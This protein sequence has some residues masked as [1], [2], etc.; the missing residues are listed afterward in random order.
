MTGT[1]LPICSCPNPH[2][3]Y[4]TT[5]LLLPPF[6][7]PVPYYPSA[8]API[9]MTGTILP[10]CSCPRSHDRYYTTHLLLPHS[11]D[12]YY[13]AHMFL[14]QS[15]DRY[16]S[17]HLLLPPFTRPVLYYPSA[18]APIHTTGTI[19]P[20]CSCPHSHELYYPSAPA[21]I[22]TTGTIQ[23]ICS[24]PHSHDRYYTTHLLL[25]PFT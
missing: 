3:R 11:H 9:H 5:H 10:I 1:I 17:A 18:P 23:P 8:P 19:L 13:T 6:T 7:R 22:H 25:P 15:H 20:I 16:Y 21:P 2:D 4:Y 12:R 14:P 24:C